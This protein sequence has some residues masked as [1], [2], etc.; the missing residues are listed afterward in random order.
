MIHR[1]NRLWHVSFLQAGLLSALVGVC[2]AVSG[3]DTET[4]SANTGTQQKSSGAPGSGNSKGGPGGN[5][6]SVITARVQESNF[7]ATVEALGTAKANEA[8]DIVAKSSNR[9]MAIHFR[10]GQNVKQGQLLVELDADE[11]RADLQVAEAALGESR[12]QF[13]RAR[14]LALTKA[15]SAQQLEQLEATLKGNEARVA[16][17]QARLNDLIIRAPFSGRVGLRSVSVGSLVG[18]GTV[19]TTLDDTSVMKL[20]FS[21]PETV[22]SSIQEGLEVQ[23][24]SAAYSSDTFHGRVITIDSRVDPVTRAVTV[25][26][27]VPNR[28]GKLKPGMFMTVRLLHGGGKTLVLPEQALVPERD[29]Q[30]V[31]GVR[32]GKA[33]KTEIVVGRR[34]PGE[35][36]ILG[37]LS[38]G[39]EVIIEGTQK[40][41]DGVAVRIAPAGGGAEGGA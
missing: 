36:E 24:K 34:R 11:V 19:I 35:V 6:P 26:A 9:V 17:A 12:S 7:S 32:D 1:S 41:R 30:F 27:Q 8:I 5:A 4:V 25:R 3:C 15:L 18:T 29:K 2:L 31:F 28:E 33:Y 40:V 37:G 38:Q 20:D 22:L 13:N 16:S 21:V 10:E 39:D 23:A 14:E